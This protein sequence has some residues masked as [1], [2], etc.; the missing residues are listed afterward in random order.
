MTVTGKFK[1]LYCPDKYF[2]LAKKVGVV[3]FRPMNTGVNANHSRVSQNG[4]IR[5]KGRD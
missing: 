1:S 4:K 5:T 2:V 3:V